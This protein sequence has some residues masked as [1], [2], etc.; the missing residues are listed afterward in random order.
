VI[1]KSACVAAVVAAL[2]ASFPGSAAANHGGPCK[3]LC[4]V[5]KSFAIIAD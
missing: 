3:Q 1:R 2:I 4:G 5:D